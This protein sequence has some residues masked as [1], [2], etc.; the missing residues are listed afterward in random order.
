MLTLQI[1]NTTLRLS[2]LSSNYATTQSSEKDFQRFP[3]YS[4]HQLLSDFWGEFLKT[5]LKFF[6]DYLS[7]S[8]C[9]SRHMSECKCLWWLKDPLKMNYQTAVSYPTWFMGTTHG[10]FGRAARALDCRAIYFFPSGASFEDTTSELHSSL[11]RQDLTKKKILCTEI[12]DF[13]QDSAGFLC[14]LESISCS[15]FMDFMAKEEIDWIRS[16]TWNTIYLGSF[17]STYR[18][19][20]HNMAQS[21]N[22]NLLFSG[23]EMLCFLRLKNDLCSAFSW[24]GEPHKMLRNPQIL[25]T[26]VWTFIPSL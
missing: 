22:K 25:H 11:G 13:K 17:S 3:I 21:V 6:W 16:C 7:V 2:P 20:K 26:L 12:W 23:V 15:G 19:S 9:E 8:V 1:I 18:I 5:S 14:D 4:P 10:S 24:N